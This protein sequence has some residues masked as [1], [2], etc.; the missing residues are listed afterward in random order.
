M[1]LR[2]GKLTSLLALQS[3]IELSVLI[4][5]VGIGLMNFGRPDDPIAL[6]AGIS[7]NVAALSII[8]YSGY[9]FMWRALKI[10]YVPSVVSF[11]SR[12]AHLSRASAGIDKPSITRIPLVHPR[13][14]R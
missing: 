11:R 3:W 6:A 1:G 5:A 13:C 2:E 4:S 8:A 12:G 14:A 10:R 9:N 7:F